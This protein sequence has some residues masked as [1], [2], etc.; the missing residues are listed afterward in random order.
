MES[1]QNGVR[2]IRVSGFT[3]ER[4][5]GAALLVCAWQ[6]FAFSQADA[7]DQMANALR[8]NVVR[9]EATMSTHVENGFG[10]VVGERGGQLYIVTAYHVVNDPDAIGVANP[11]KAKVE[12]FD[13]QGK[14]YKAEI[15]GTHDENRDL[16]VLTVPSPAGFSWKEKCLAGP[17]KQKHGVPV[18]FIG[19]DQKWKPPVAP[20]HVISGPSTEWMI[21]LEGTSVKPGS[22]GGPIISDTGII[23]MIETDSSENTRALSIDFIKRAFETWNHPWGLEA[24]EKDKG[25]EPTPSK[26]D[27]DEIAKIIQRYADAYNHRD[28]NALWG[29]WPSPPSNTKHVIENSFRSASSIAM[30]VE[31]DPIEPNGSS[32]VVTGQYSQEFTAKD[33]QQQKSKGNIR[34]DLSKQSGSW[35]VTSVR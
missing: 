27:A 10:F 29:I 24:T 30:S 19:R 3:F 35:V 21:D 13:N 15:L 26:T 22:S 6:Q 31:H 20:G 2:K 11:V 5:V 4:I 14:L 9:V 33:G 28:A 32:A 7:S 1:K 17:E 12:F 8:Q 25:K 23:G 18:W 16:A 34:F